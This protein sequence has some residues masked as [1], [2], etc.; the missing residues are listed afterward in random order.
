MKAGNQSV[1][2]PVYAPPSEDI[3]V[4]LGKRDTYSYRH[5]SYIPS[6]KL[7]MPSIPAILETR[8]TRLCAGFGPSFNR[9]SPV[10]R[11]KMR[12]G[13]LGDEGE[14]KV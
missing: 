12:A 11:S 2:H 8:E 3:G 9:I 13:A 14:V 5:T 1:R 6:L 7:I 4:R 10:G